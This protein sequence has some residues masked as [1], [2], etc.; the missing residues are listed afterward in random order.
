MYKW[1]EHICKALVNGYAG[2]SE[3][4]SRLWENTVL[5]SGLLCSLAGFAII[6]PVERVAGG[7]L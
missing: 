7:V 5:L 4:A 2:V 1:I 6:F 3:A